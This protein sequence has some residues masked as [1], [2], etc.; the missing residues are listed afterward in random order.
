MQSAALP[1]ASGWETSTRNSAP[2]VVCARRQ[3]HVSAPFYPATSTSTSVASCLPYRDQHCPL[4]F[5][6]LTPPPN[7]AT[8]NLIPDPATYLIST[9]FPMEMLLNES[10]FI[11]FPSFFSLSLFFSFSLYSGLYMG[12]WEEERGEGL[13][14]KFC[15]FFEFKRKFLKRLSLVYRFVF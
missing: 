2:S 4:L 12:F 10:P 6:V 11:A 1:T 9:A 3:I 8:F 5:T 7:N 15:F 14:D 13:A